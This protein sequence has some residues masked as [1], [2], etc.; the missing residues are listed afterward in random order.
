MKSPIFGANI[1]TELH[2]WPPGRAG[3]PRTVLRGARPRRRR[4]AQRN[5]DPYAPSSPARRKY[6]RNPVRNRRACVHLFATPAPRLF[7]ASLP[8]FTLRHVL[9]IARRR[10]RIDCLT[11]SCR[12]AFGW[13]KAGPSGSPSRFCCLRVFPPGLD[14]ASLTGNRNFR[15][16]LRRMARPI[17]PCRQAARMD[18]FCSYSRFG[19]YPQICLLQGQV[20]STCS[21]APHGGVR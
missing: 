11:S 5:L 2:R 18:R 14:H 1:K 6:R 10:P 19:N 8:D 7:V 4:A 17:Q 20:A 21:P 15:L 16:A 12:M 9:V 13:L 3:H